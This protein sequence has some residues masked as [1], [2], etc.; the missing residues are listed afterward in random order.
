MN[1]GLRDASGSD[2][3]R[4]VILSMRQ[5]LYFMEAARTGT[6]RAISSENTQVLL[7]LVSSMAIRAPVAAQQ[8]VHE[9]P[10]HQYRQA[11]AKIR[12]QMSAR[13]DIPRTSVKMVKLL[14]RL[15]DREPAVK[16]DYQ[17]DRQS[18]DIESE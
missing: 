17:R 5:V 2:F 18:H 16:L 10:E 14:P 13:T 15:H 11:S 7:N 1:A 9:L 4:A 3:G 8:Q 12:A 6:N